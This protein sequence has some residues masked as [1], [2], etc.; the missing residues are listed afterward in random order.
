[1]S[2]E[3]GEIIGLIRKYNKLTQDECKKWFINNMGI[4]LDNNSITIDYKCDTYNDLLLVENPQLG[5]IAEITTSI[6]NQWWNV[7]KS[8]RLKGIYAYNGTEW[9][10]SDFT[11]T[12]RYSP[13][14]N[15]DSVN[16]NEIRLWSP[17]VLS[18]F[19]SNADL[20]SVGGL[21][22]DDTKIGLI[23]D[24]SLWSANKISSELDNKVDKINNK[25]LLLDTEITKLQ[26]ISSGANKV[27][28][29]SSNG[30]II[31]DSIEKT[32]YAHPTGSNP[33]NTTKADIGLENVPNV[34][35][36]NQTP[37]FT[38]ALSNSNLISGEIITTSF[39]KIAKAISSLISHISDLVLHVTET[40]R[41]NW[42]SA[43]ANSHAHNNKATL[44]NTTASYTA[45]EQTK[46][47]GV[48][49]GANNYALPIAS[50]IIGGIKSGTDISI[51]GSGNVSVVNYSHNHQISNIDDLQTTV[52]NIYSRLGAL[53][54]NMNNSIGIHAMV[55]INKDGSIVRSTGNISSVSRTAAGCYTIG[56]I[57]AYMSSDYLVFA[58]TTNNS[59]AT[60][61]ASVS[62]VSKSST[63]VK[64]ASE[65]LDGNYADYVIDL[66]IVK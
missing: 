6:N 19:I 35:T 24:N 27:E 37:T 31:V 23:T 8:T 36:N 10:R 5:Q 43:Y 41:S 46:L 3:L 33:H 61:V 56:F 20:D 2:A 63:N 9:I 57:M 22:V 53:E 29:S 38:M 66:I 13:S 7:I 18:E 52:D 11:S 32:V 25:S 49:T 59:G 50:T 28:V 62:I 26:G 42:G 54:S 64:I 51:D 40:E 14:E 16:T 21:H 58:T 17:K 44:D 45:A 39:G 47:A 1:M 30:N 12:P 34:T 4:D 65:D 55:V 15:G 48:A 60:D